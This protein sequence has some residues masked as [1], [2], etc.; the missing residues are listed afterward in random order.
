LKGLAQSYNV[1]DLDSQTWWSFRV[2]AVNGVGA[3]V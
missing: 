1:T 3:G 2:R